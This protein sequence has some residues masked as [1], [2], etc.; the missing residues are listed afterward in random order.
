[1]GDDIAI[2]LQGVWK[3]YGL[4]LPR[5]LRRASRWWRS[6]GDGGSRS[7][8]SDDDGPWVLQDIN[9]EVRRGETLAIVGRNGAAKSTLLKVLAGVT[10]PTRGQVDVRGRVFPMIEITG[11]LHPELT[12]REIIRL[13]GA[14]LGLSRRELAALLPDI[15]A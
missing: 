8:A 4:P 5:W 14:I 1:M 11:G 6:L 2:R 3:R 15:E 10:P 7:A 12:G 13:I 9:L